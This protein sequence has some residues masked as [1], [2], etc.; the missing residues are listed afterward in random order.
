MT[1]DSTMDLLDLLDTLALAAR[2]ANTPAQ[3]KAAAAALRRLYR[4]LVADGWPLA[5]ARDVIDHVLN[6]GSVASWMQT[7]AAF[8]PVS[9]SPA[10]HAGADAIQRRPARHD[11]APAPAAVRADR[12]DDAPSAGPADAV[13]EAH[14]RWARHRALARA[15]ASNTTA[16]GTPS[17][18]RSGGDA[19][20]AARRSLRADGGESAP[21]AG[22]GSGVDGGDDG[23]EICFDPWPYDVERD[24]FDDDDFVEHTFR[25]RNEW[26]VDLIECLGE[27]HGVRVW[28]KPREKWS[29]LHAEADWGS[30]RALLEDYARLSWDL[31]DWIDEWI[32]DA[33]DE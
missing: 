8:G 18:R 31:T 20:D 13:D 1:D 2:Q 11:D 5:Q 16:D 14:E 24:A 12:D 32:D 4:G 15:T 6:G 22:R 33:M 29:T 26:A 10:P 19:R 3:K 27:R 30:L 9:R 17:G 7:I 23:R 21:M 25:V 28:R